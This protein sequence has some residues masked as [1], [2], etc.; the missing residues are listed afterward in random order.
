[1]MKR[2]SIVCVV[3]LGLVLGS[4]GAAMA[5][6]TRGNGTD[7]E[8]NGKARSACHYSGLDVADA[9]EGNPPGLDDDWAGERGNQSPGGE[10]R[11]HGVQNWGAYVKAG[12]SG[13]LTEMGLHPG[14]ACRGNAVFEE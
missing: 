9:D 14:M 4:G 3:A 12:A 1:M 6:E 11:Y 7:N 8:N 5:G 13:M 10:D 2:A